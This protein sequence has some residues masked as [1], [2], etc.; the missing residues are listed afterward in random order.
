MYQTVARVGGESKTELRGGY[1]NSQG[2]QWT[3]ADDKLLQTRWNAGE[4][5]A[6][7]GADIGKGVSRC[8]VL[9]RVSRLRTRGWAMESRSTVRHDYK[10]RPTRFHNRPAKP[11]HA[12]SNPVAHSKPV[13]D[14]TD[15]EAT[16]PP[17][18]R[19]KFHVAGLPQIT[20]ER[21]NARRA[22]ELLSDEATMSTDLRCACG[23]PGTPHCAK[24]RD[25]LRQAGVL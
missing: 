14:F 10:D 24:H 23:A 3:E 19:E 8:S 12:K 17:V 15:I 25:M 9:G 6:T 1:R 5:P 13:F 20:P 2:H 16:P 18:V 22:I 4:N 11:R 21:I 7:I